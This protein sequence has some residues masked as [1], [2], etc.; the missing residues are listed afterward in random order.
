M[1]LFRRKTP[2]EKAAI[3][4]E[5]ALNGAYGEKRRR[6]WNAVISANSRTF[7]PEFE[8]VLMP[9][10]AD[11][12][13]EAW[14][15]INPDPS[16]EDLEKFWKKDL[17]RLGDPY[18]WPSEFSRESIKLGGRMGLA[19]LEATTARL[20]AD[21]IARL[22]DVP[23]TDVRDGDLLGE[24]TAWSERPIRPGTE[25]SDD[26]AVPVDAADEVDESGAAEVDSSNASF[27]DVL[28]L[29]L[30][31]YKPKLSDEAIGRLQPILELIDSSPIPAL[32]IS[33]WVT[34]HLPD[35]AS[36]SE[37]DH[38]EQLVDSVQVWFDKQPPDLL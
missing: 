11:E 10:W 18:Y 2:E 32:E 33:S 26:V 13:A 36:E 35:E 1:G 19:V 29:W 15:R 17:R 8:T 37:R 12:A 5:R 23:S 14:L 38:I 16:N 22:G 4:E 34:D 30:A 24:M 9:M 25:R 28:R 21:R 31:E 27:G 20:E 3:A 6:L 7:D